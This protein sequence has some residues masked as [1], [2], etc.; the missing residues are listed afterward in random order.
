MTSFIS[1]RSALPASSPI[2]LVLVDDHAVLRA[3]LAHRI[4]I[5]PES[6]RQERNRD[7][8]IRLYES[9]VQEWKFI[10][11]VYSGK[12]A[13]CPADV[14][15][16]ALTISHLANIAIRLGRRSARA[17]GVGRVPFRLRAATFLS[18][19]CPSLSVFRSSCWKGVR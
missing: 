2:R 10:D 13:I 16:R 12:P 18:K 6:L 8:D 14:S 3:G 11:C 7:D 17:G 5:R 1:R 9:K 19:G 4:E 15:H